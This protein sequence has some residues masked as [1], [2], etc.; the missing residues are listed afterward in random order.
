MKILAQLTTHRAW[1]N[2]QLPAAFLIALLQRSPV[3]RLAQAVDEF[4]TASPVGALLRSTV[5]AAASL[6]TLHS[7]AGAT[8]LSA[9]KASPVAVT[10]GSPIAAIAFT[11]TNTINIASWKIG[12]TL[13]PGLTLSATEGGASLTGPGTLDATTTGMDDGYGGMTGGIASTT[14][15]LV[16]TPTQ[17]GI[18]TFSLQAY[19]FARLTGLASNTF[20]Y[21]IN[22]AGSAP[23][24]VTPTVTAQP[25]SRAVDAGSSTSLSVTAT[26][27]G[28]AAPTFQ[29][30][31]N[32]SDLGGATGATLTLDNVQPANAGVYT[33]V[34]A[35]GATTT[36]DP[37][38]VGVTTTN[39]VIG[40]G[41][42]LSLDIKHPNGNVFDQVLLDGTAETITADPGKVTR[43]SFIDLSDDIVQ[44]EFSGAGTLTIVLDNP[45]GP[46]SPVNYNQAVNYMKGHAGI[47]IT[48]ADDTTNVSVF[49]VGR[50]TAFDPTG[51][52]NILLPISSTNNP[53]NNGSSLFQGRS[54][55]V[56]D[57]LA[58]LSF[59]AISST[60]GKFGGLRTSNGSYFATKGFTGVYA[61]GVQ[62]QGPVFIGDISASDAATPVIM[63]GSSPDTRI[64]GGDLLQ[65]NGRAVQVSGLTALKFT[66]GGDSQGN[67]LTAKTNRAVLQQSGVDVT[68]Q[69]VVNSSP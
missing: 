18:Y 24:V 23:A 41:H 43:T 5:A 55:T 3:V 15:V 35:S 2:I 58:G 63:I 48:G 37:A 47:V 66:A 33:A 31:R 54:G 59:I 46:A 9:S 42:V 39:K 26:A 34:I 11:V 67:A 65:A 36:S 14:P 60:N 40:V 8:T 50:A 64:T 6:G 30:Q 1:M 21:S 38:I 10:A 56:Y 61:P 16:G 13:P 28:G 27:S 29:W 68:T 62:F 4:V 12:G 69:I 25:A 52:F 17:P 51:G 57:G 45:S 20:S 49:T 32:G 7:L 19:E 53:A 44:V 22:V